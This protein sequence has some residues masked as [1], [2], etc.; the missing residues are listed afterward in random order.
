[1][2]SQRRAEVRDALDLTRSEVSCAIV[3]FVAGAGVAGAGL[4]PNVTALNASVS[5][6]TTFW[7]FLELMPVLG[8]FAPS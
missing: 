3:S 4:S 5:G 8:H 1:M 6:L 7:R 2:G